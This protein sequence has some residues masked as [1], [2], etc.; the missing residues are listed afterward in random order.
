MNKKL[1]GELRYIDLNK[2]N[3]HVKK[4]QRR[5]KGG[6]NTIAWI[7]CKKEDLIV[8]DTNHLSVSDMSEIIMYITLNREI[9]R[10][11]TYPSSNVLGLS[12]KKGMSVIDTRRLPIESYS[13]KKKRRVPNKE[14][15]GDE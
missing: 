2:Y 10:R 12:M 7:D 15:K 13:K 6:W 4:V 11:F 5:R 1:F 9:W 8:F 14:G 3:N